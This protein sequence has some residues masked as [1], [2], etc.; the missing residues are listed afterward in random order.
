MSE[1]FPSV[2][3][4]VYEQAFGG[5]PYARVE[6]RGSCIKLSIQNQ[7]G[8]GTQLCYDIFPG[9]QIIYN[10]LDMGETRSMRNGVLS[11]SISSGSPT[12]V[13]SPV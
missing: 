13:R 10:C 2:P 6:H 12:T 8:R 3:V 5:Y 7:T 11:G 1:S 4:A 9:A